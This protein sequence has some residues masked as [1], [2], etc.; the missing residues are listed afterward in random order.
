MGGRL[1][2]FPHQASGQPLTE[3]SREQVA[4]AE[5]GGMR[6][7]AVLGMV[8]LSLVAVRPALGASGSVAALQI[9]L[10]AHGLYGGPIDGVG[11][12]L[13]K[14]GVLRL[15][16]T[17][18]ISAT[19]RVGAKT[20]RALG[21][22]GRPL[23]GQRLLSPGLAGWDVAALE[24]RLTAYGLP[25]AAVDGRFD[26]STAAALRRFQA[27]RGLTPDGVAGTEDV[28]RRSPVP[29]SGAL[30]PRRWRST[31]SR[32]A[33]ASSASRRTTASARGSSPGRIASR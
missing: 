18:G 20:R 21:M 4:D 7:V 16:L 2:A 23:L 9:G 19:G 15:Q 3:S 31:S 24:F 17:N 29:S 8:L 11:G 1:E 26:L 6:R 5:F 14:A 33:R 28:P 27:A 30:G 12:P 13:T 25:G 22:W 10:R 32:Q